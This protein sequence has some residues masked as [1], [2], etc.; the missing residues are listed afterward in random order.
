MCH[1]PA[2]QGSPFFNIFSDRLLGAF[3]PDDS[4]SLIVGRSASAGGSLERYV[5]QIQQL[6]G[7]FP[8]FLQMACC[9]AFEQQQHNGTI[10]LPGV[11]QKFR[12]EVRP[13]VQHLWSRLLPAEQEVVERVS[14]DAPV[15]QYPAGLLRDLVRRGYL[16]G[17]SLHSGSFA[18]DCRAVGDFVRQLRV[19]EPSGLPGRVPRSAAA[20][21]ARAHRTDSST[22]YPRP[23]IHQLL[24]SQ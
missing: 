4:Y 11:A 10:D 6:A 23:C 18:L 3:S 24:A 2:V 19:P 15:N 17:P 9:Y 16:V 12:E 21:E 13:Y 1:S 14:A 8:L 22:G 5:D 20:A 7:R